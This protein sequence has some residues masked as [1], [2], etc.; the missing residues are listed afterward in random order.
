[1]QHVFYFV[2]L[3]DLNPNT[4]KNM[5]ERPTTQATMLLSVRVRVKFISIYCLLWPFYSLDVS[6][7]ATGYKKPATGVTGLYA[8]FCLFD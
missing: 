3:R 6:N 4:I 2:S 5:T 1:M 8:G 7:N